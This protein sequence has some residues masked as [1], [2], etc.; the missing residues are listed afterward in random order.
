M[1]CSMY[2]TYCIDV[3]HGKSWNI[4]CQHLKHL[5]ICKHFSGWKYSHRNN[6]S[7]QPH[8]SQMVNLDH[9]YQINTPIDAQLTL[10]QNLINRQS[11]VSQLV[12]INRKLVDCRPG[13]RWCADRVSTEMQMECQSS[14]NWLSME[15]WSKVSIEGV[16]Q[17]YR[18]TLDSRCFK[19][20]WSINSSSIHTSV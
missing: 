13:G 12:C 4:H 1:Y 19:Y 9:V 17:G 15:G 10:N 16:S 2:C 18:S 14:I 5:T 11:I 6:T 7:F 20:T 8:K 3:R